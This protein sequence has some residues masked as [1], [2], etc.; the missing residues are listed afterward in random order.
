MSEKGNCKPAYL[1]L[2]YGLNVHEILRC[3][4]ENPNPYCDCIWRWELWKVIRFRRGQESETPPNHT[5]KGIP[6]L[7]T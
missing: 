4:D 7:I 5:H 1:G 2:Y 6:E 3:I